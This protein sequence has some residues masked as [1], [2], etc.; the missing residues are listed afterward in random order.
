M[1]DFPC[2]KCSQCCR[3]VG[4]VIANSSNLPQKVQDLISIFP[5]EVKPDGSCSMLLDDGTCKVYDNRPIICNIKLT[6]SIFNY[7][8]AEWYRINADMCNTYIR[9]AGLSDDYLV[10]LEKPAKE[11][12]KTYE[13][14]RTSPRKKRRRKTSPKRT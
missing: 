2:T 7:D 5:Y 14:G 11:T 9:E 3:N 8:L 4:K 13:E 12:Y 6:A 10:K 1:D